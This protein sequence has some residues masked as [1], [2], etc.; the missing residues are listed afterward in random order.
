M[1]AGGFGVCVLVGGGGSGGTGILM[2]ELSWAHGS[3]M[4]PAG[5]WALEKVIQFPEVSLSLKCVMSTP[6]GY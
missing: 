5:R 6:W 3:S 2:E 1:A 4:A